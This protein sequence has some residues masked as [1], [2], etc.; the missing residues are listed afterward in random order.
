VA[1]AFR[2]VPSTHATVRSPG[3]VGGACAASNTVSGPRRRAAPLTQEWNALGPPAAV[4]HA[5]GC[6]I[7]ARALDQSI[8]LLPLDLGKP[9]A[10]AA[11]ARRPPPGCRGGA[12]APLNFARRCR[13]AC[14]PPAAS[15]QRAPRFKCFDTPPLRPRETMPFAVFLPPP[16]PPLLAPGTGACWALALRQRGPAAGSGH[17]ARRRC[18]APWPAQQPHSR[19]VAATH[20]VSGAAGRVPPLSALWAPPLSQPRQEPSPLTGLRLGTLTPLRVSKPPSVPLAPRNTGPRWRAPPR[21]CPRPCPVSAGID[22]GPAVARQ[23]CCRSPQ[24]RGPARAQPPAR[25][26]AG[27]GAARADRPA[28]AP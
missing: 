13:G 12:S 17:A 11:A 15:T 14:G 7:P 5:A 18:R 8:D 21:G 26:G 16:P 2:H 20:R 23:G 24:A 19:P 28:P 3:S 1:A 4:L 6:R 25:R 27:G 10:C 9:R 22:R